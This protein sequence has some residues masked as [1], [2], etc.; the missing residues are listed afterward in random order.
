MFEAV[1]QSI[2]FESIRNFAIQTQAF[3]G[4]LNLNHDLSR[5]YLSYKHGMTLSLAANLTPQ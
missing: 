2:Q 4:E 1:K 3:N 5:Y